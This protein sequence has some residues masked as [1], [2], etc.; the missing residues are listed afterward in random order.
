MFFKEVLVDDTFVPNA[1]IGIVAIEIDG[2]KVPE[3]K[4]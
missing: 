4:V 2:E 3:Y 1:Y